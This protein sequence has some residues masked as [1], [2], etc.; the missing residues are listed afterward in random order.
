M[1]NNLQIFSSNEFG[2]IRVIK[3]NG[4]EYF[5]GKDVATA[6]GYA[7][8]INAIKRH[9]RGAGVAKRHLGVQTG[10]KADGTPSIQ[11]IETT[12]ID[13]GNLYRLIT[14]SK[15]PSAENFERWVFDEVLPTIRKTGSYAIKEDNAKLKEQ[16]LKT[17]EENVKVRKAQLMY[18]ISQEVNIPEYK[19]VLQSHITT[20]LTGK[21]LLPL[22]QIH[23]HTYS[24]EEI[25]NELGIS[26]NKVGR[27]AKEYNL[28]TEEYGQW[29]WDKSRSSN[30]QVESFRYYNNVVDKLRE[31]MGGVL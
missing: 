14:H 20:M 9:C 2:Q 30:K 3:E 4:K 17:R 23:K 31:I 6:L 16:M 22:P 21:E 12:F 5:C 18:K 27:L 8:S 24:A 10:I 28:K 13:E 7:D 1:K 25:G 15:L 26:S 11:K 19:Q 29:V